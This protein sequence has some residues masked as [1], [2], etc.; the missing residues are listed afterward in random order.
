[1]ITVAFLATVA[2]VLAA[3]VL[4]IAIAARHARRPFPR[5]ALVG[6]AGWLAVT[7]FLAAAGV[8]ELDG[9]PPRVVLLAI[10]ATTAL[11]VVAHRCR[12]ADHL[13][14]AHVIALQL[15]RLP[16]EL[17]LWRLYV[18]GSIPIQ[19]TFEGRNF[20]VLVALTAIP[21]ALLVARGASH[22]V[23]LGWHL[24]GLA[25]LVNIVVT[26]MLSTPGPLRVF[27][28]EPAN[29]IVGELPFV[30]LPAL[31]VPIAFASHVVGIRQALKR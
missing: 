24:F 3:L 25:M 23:V 15:F 19:M 29:V 4:L 20:D 16:V 1:M 6:L 28:N 31:L 8:T 26:A 14:P 10:I 7:G 12:I 22:R 21:V 2:A 27:T 17:V 18:D 30:W 9:G 5:A 13:S 11:T